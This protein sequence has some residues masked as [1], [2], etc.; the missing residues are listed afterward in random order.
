MKNIPHHDQKTFMKKLIPSVQ[1]LIHRMR[2]KVFWASRS[3]SD[4]TPDRNSKNKFG[5]KTQKT[6]PQEDPEL[7]RFETKLYDLICNIKFRQP[8]KTEFSSR[9]ESDIKRLKRSNK[10]WVKADK[11]TNYYELDPETYET[12][13]NNAITSNYKKCGE[14]EEHVIN[15]GARNIAKE[16]RI[17]DRTTKFSRQDAF[18]TLKD[19]KSDF[20]TKPSVR[21]I[22]PAKTDIGKAAKQMLD[23]IIS[24]VRKARKDRG[25]ELVQ[26]KNSAEVIQ[27]FRETE[28]KK[29]TFLQ[30][31]ID[32]FYPSI[33]LQLMKKALDWAKM[34]T[35]VSELEERTILHSKQS[36]LF[37]KQDVW[38]KKDGLF[39]VTMGSW[40]GAEDS[41]LVGLLLLDR[42]S[43]DTCLPLK[44]L[45]LYR[46]D[47][48][49]IIQNANGPHVER[50]RKIITRTFKQEGLKV[51]VGTSS[52]VVDFL[53]ITLDL[54]DGSFTPYTKPDNPLLYVDVNSNHPAKI[55]RNIPVMIERRINGLSS[56]SNKF[57]SAKPTYEAALKRSGYDHN[58]EFKDCEEQRRTKRRR[59]RKV[60]WFTP[61]YSNGVQTNIAT[62]FLQLLDTCF[63]QGHHLRKLFN[64]KTVKVSWSTLPNIGQIITSHNKRTLRKRSRQETERTCNCRGAR[65]D[66][67]PLE[68]NCLKSG[69]IYEAQVTAGGDTYSY[70]GLTE[71][72]FKKRFT[73][74]KSSF[75]RPA[76]RK[77]TELSKKIWE[78]KDNDTEFQLRWSILDRGTP[79]PGTHNCDL[80]IT[81]KLWIIKNAKRRDVI[82]LNRRSE[83]AGGCRHR[84][85]HLLKSFMKEEDGVLDDDEFT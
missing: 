23:R 1:S 75:R 66:E 43:K 16:L 29:A 53:D 59:T 5:F 35:K 79:T 22:N 54:T 74:H 83:I 48:L 14:N 82:P 30:F 52:K 80:C 45:G 73:A 61:P 28:K 67:C 7:T 24:D 69:V 17:E 57:A 34:Y 78:L 50:L 21:L 63:P 56:D 77:A 65:K 42:L 11:T 15:R 58:F 72:P 2:W 68:G 62:K 27:W 26:W 3:D 4:E 41:D 70:V 71:G 55:K 44:S 40:D 6:P 64:R 85:K 84:A 13:L 37:S 19:H 76:A 81:E 25:E 33:T 32:S 39:D 18:L 60:I 47:G 31:D 46:D 8:R 20:R 49:L 12:L 9:L 51:T 10:I 38:M 36:L